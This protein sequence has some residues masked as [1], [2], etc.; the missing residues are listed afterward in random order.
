MTGI[1]HLVFAEILEMTFTGNS[2]GSLMLT[3]AADSYSVGAFAAVAENRHTACA[4][5]IFS[6]VMLAVL[7]GNSLTQHLFYTLVVKL[8]VL[9]GYLLVIVS[10][11]FLRLVQPVHKLLGNILQKIYILEKFQK[12]TVELIKLAFGL[13]KNASAKIIKFRER[14]VS[15]AFVQ[16]LIKRH[17]LGHG[18]LKAL[19]PE[20]IQK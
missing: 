12:C 18:H 17:P 14:G 8:K 7:L 15:H 13:N 16:S 19:R 11:C 9:S 10:R 6:A 20:K 2:E 1:K 4:Y 5:P 3:F